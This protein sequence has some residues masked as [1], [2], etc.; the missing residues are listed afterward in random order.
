M[1]K[2]I[3]ILFLEDAEKFFH[4]LPQKMKDK[5]SISFYK[6]KNG[7]KGPWFEKLKGTDGIFEFREKGFDKY[8]RIFAFWDKTPEQETL[9]IG[10]HGMD[11]KTNKTPAKEIKKAESI[12]KMYFNFK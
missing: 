9:I 11:K 2:N 1:K 4:G 10:T 7:Y 12:K 8:Y 6:V 5:F 3:E